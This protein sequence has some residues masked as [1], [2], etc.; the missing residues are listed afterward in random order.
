MHQQNDY[1]PHLIIRNLL[2]SSLLSPKRDGVA[3]EL[4]VLLDKVLQSAF[5][6]VLQLILLQMCLTRLTSSTVL[7]GQPVRRP[8]WRHGI[9]KT[10]AHLQVQNDLGPTT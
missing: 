4:T 5:L 6:K 2:L 7:K 1:K 9:D 8:A 10:K 3:D